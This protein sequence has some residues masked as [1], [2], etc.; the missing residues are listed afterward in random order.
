MLP[1]ETHA[2]LPQRESNRAQSVAAQAWPTPAPAHLL[3]RGLQLLQRGALLLHSSQGLAQPRLAGLQPLQG[4]PQ[5]RLAQRQR[6]LRLGPLLLRG[7]QRCLGVLCLTQQSLLCLLP[8]LRGA[9]HGGGGSCRGSGRRRCCPLLLQLLG[10]RGGALLGRCC[11][12]ASHVQLNVRRC[13]LG[14]Q[15]IHIAMGGRRQLRRVLHLAHLWA[16]AG[17]RATLG[18]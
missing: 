2:L 17:R 3:Q 5:L 6:L 14:A 4:L 18:G 11:S 15:G 1:H 16:G 8:L 7:A 13:Q 12:L 10:K 9:L